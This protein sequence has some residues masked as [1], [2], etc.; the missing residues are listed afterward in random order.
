MHSESA[1]DLQ[2]IPSTAPPAANRIISGFW[3]RML[4]FLLDCLILFV[5]AI[6][7][8][9]LLFD[10]YAELGGWGRLLGFCIALMYFGLFNSSLGHG[11]TLGKRLLKIEVVNVSG[12]YI[13]PGRSLLRFSVLAAP[14]FLNRPPI[15]LSE[16]MGPLGYTMALL[17][18][19]LGG[20]ILYMYIFNRRTRQSLHDLA[21]GTWVVRTWPKGPAP[22][23]SVWQTHLVAVGI[24]FL[25]VLGFCVF[26]PYLSQKGAFPD[27]LAA[28]RAIESSGK[29][30]VESAFDSTT[31]K[32]TG[33]KKPNVTFFQT[34]VILEEKPVNFEAAAATARGIAAIILNKYPGVNDK[35]FLFINMR[36]G[37][38]LGIAWSWLKWSFN[39]SA[40]Q[41]QEFLNQPERMMQ[42]L[43]QQVQQKGDSKGA[44]ETGPQDV[45][46]LYKRGLAHYQKKEWDRAIAE[47]DRA[48][49]LNPRYADALHKRG[50]AYYF[51]HDWDQAI[52]NFNRVLELHPDFAKDYYNR[53]LAYYYKKELDRAIA[54]FSR[55]LELNPKDHEAYDMRGR[56]F[57]FKGDMGRALADYS[58]ALELNPKYAEA[59]QD[60][61]VVYHRQG[62]LDQAIA[63]YNEA[64]KLNPRYAKAH[65][66][67]GMVYAKKEDLGRAIADFDRALELNPRYAEAYMH[68]GFAY[69]KRGDFDRA[70]ADYSRLLK[71]KPDDGSA[72]HGRGLA[73]YGKRD[74]DRALA[75]YNRAL[76][77]D[78]KDAKVHYVKAELLDK[79]GTKKE[80]LEAYRSFLRY[81]PPEAKEYVGRAQKRVKALEE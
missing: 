67:R 56:A 9:F 46:A 77:L 7:S 29:W 10:F 65:C 20:A 79:F 55:G 52:A 33:E 50:L 24:W 72:Y 44:L 71:L 68:R 13:S 27:M 63:D 26:F 35:N 60:R 17:M 11:Q 43:R 25:A 70:I 6:L 16:V 39:Y 31:W 22:G 45:K 57:C 61:G 37:Y 64:L 51:K 66:N 3:R 2:D 58:Q 80:A 34:V 23:V 47:F 12:D 49:E 36:Y 69:Y 62:D 75:D 19:G 8:G 48:V 81:A 42:A 74:Y 53:G 5:P 78:P 21:A 40:G 30:R 59:Y 28:A 15:H 32:L 38:D 18:S 41:W 4:S 73:Y 14:W 54:D 1:P 76:G